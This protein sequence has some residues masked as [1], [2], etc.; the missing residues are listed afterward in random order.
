MWIVGL[1]MRNIDLDDERFRALSRCI[2]EVMLEPLMPANRKTFD[3]VISYVG[4]CLREFGKGL[5]ADVRTS[6][7]RMV[8]SRLPIRCIQELVQTDTLAQFVIGTLDR[9]IYVGTGIDLRQ[10]DVIYASARAIETGEA[11]RVRSGNGAEY[12]LQFDS[13]RLYLSASESPSSVIIEFPDL[14]ICA[15]DKSTRLRALDEILAASSP[16]FAHGS[17]LRSS[18]ETRELHADEVNEVLEERTSG[19][20]AKWRKIEQSWHSSIDISTFAPA[21]VRYYAQFCGP[22]PEGQ[23][24]SDYIEDTLRPLRAAQIKENL[25][26]GLKLALWGNVDEKLS[27]ADWFESIDDDDLWAAIEVVD[28]KTSPFA[29]LG[30]IDICIGRAYD[31]RFSKFLEAAISAL[32]KSTMERDD[33]V[34]AYDLTVSVARSALGFLHRAEGAASIPP[35]WKQMCSWMQAGVVMSASANVRIGDGAELINWI[36]AQRGYEGAVGVVLDLQREPLFAAAYMDGE[37]LYDEILSRLRLLI[38]RHESTGCKI[39][40]EEVLLDAIEARSD[41]DRLALVM[42]S[43]MEGARKGEEARVPNEED[44]ALLD[45]INPE[46]PEHIWGNLARLSQT[47][48]FSQRFLDGLNERLPS[49]AQDAPKEA[50][51]R[52]LNRLLSASFVATANAAEKLAY[53]IGNRVVDAAP[54]ISSSAE[55]TTVYNVIV[56]A[57]GAIL[58]SSKRELWMSHLFDKVAL[59][60]PQGEASSTWTTLLLMT[61]NMMDWRNDV[62]ARP[63]LRMSA[64]SEFAD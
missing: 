35:F 15:E 58:D 43:P 50:S 25:K 64:A 61:R 27:P 26:V 34:D 44:V 24:S 54:F 10:T 28:V 30:A 16:F 8:I 14:L 37:A 51:E 12:L 52:F 23:K 9:R 59:H 60:V 56:V 31:S 17:A 55:A 7:L 57:A 38:S 45:V 32:L 13:Q 63:L 18:A 20:S 33:G 1:F 49:F 3:R 6:V 36:D 41:A 40:F 19:V 11:Q 2:D 53:A 21:D 39:P 47:Y 29:L 46:A 4:D 5:P 48:R 62:V 42:P 22:V